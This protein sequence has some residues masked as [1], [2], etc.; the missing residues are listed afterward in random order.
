[1][2]SATTQCSSDR[3]LEERERKKR[4]SIFPS[5]TEHELEF[6]LK[7][8]ACQR[9]HER[10]ERWTDL[11][12]NVALKIELSCIGNQR[13]QKTKSCHTN[14]TNADNYSL[15]LLEEK[16]ARSTQTL[17]DAK[18]HQIRPLKHTQTLVKKWEELF[19]KKIRKRSMWLS[20]LKKRAC[21]R[22]LLQRNGKTSTHTHN[23]EDT[24]C[25][26]L[27]PYYSTTQSN[28]GKN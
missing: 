3:E 26:N 2:P 20:V 10:R 28:K 11:S 9:R 13:A 19:L 1:M 8:Q 15:Q 7:T 22:S 17:T 5:P 16:N 25:H 23:V 21:C 4:K 24:H 18:L 6:A 14:F 27:V 12:R